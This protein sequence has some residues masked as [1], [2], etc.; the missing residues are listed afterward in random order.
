MLRL[1]ATSLH[2]PSYLPGNISL[3]SLSFIFGGLRGVQ[4]RIG[5]NR[6]ENLQIL[7]STGNFMKWCMEAQTPIGVLYGVLNGEIHEE[8][9]MGCVLW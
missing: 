1:L 6:V 3:C 5:S 2:P 8:C 9:C 4:P 7:L